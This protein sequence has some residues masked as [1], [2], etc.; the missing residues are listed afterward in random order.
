MM[1]GLPGWEREA[2]SVVGVP[3]PAM[4]SSMK[5]SARGSQVWNVEHIDHYGAAT[6]LLESPGLG[7]LK[8]GARQRLGI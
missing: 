2:E 8:A 6:G 4:P 3:S 5:G 7:E 1:R